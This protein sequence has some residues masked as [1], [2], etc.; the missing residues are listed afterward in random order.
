VTYIC[1]LSPIAPC[2]RACWRSIRHGVDQGLC[3]R[4]RKQ[5]G[6]NIWMMGGAGIIWSFIDEDAIDEFIITV[7]P[8]F[9][10]EGIP[11][12]APS[13]LELPLR[14]LSSQRFS[15]GV[16]QIDYELRQLVRC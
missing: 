13:Y 5:V 14:L 12:I 6:K 10:G 3:E 7:V 4:L 2:I 1:V 11:L 15:D 9:I 8:T 16:I